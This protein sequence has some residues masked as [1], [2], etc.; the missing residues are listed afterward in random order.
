MKELETQNDDQQQPAELSED[1]SIDLSSE[2]PELLS[3][4]GELL[5]N[6]RKELGLTPATVSKQ[7]K[8]TASLIE[9]IENDNYANIGGLTYVKGYL[10]MYAKLLKLSEDEVMV[11]FEQS[12]L[13][14]TISSN[15]EKV[16]LSSVD[17]GS[18]HDK[19]DIKK[20]RW[21]AYA[22]AAVVSLIFINWLVTSDHQAAKSRQ[23][24]VTTTTQTE[25][26][27][28]A[29]SIPLNKSIIVPF[30]HSAVESDK[31][32]LSAN[33]SVDN[34]SNTNND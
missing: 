17:L 28:A 18:H 21:F 2:P 4:L 22:G 20:L 33:K 25:S 30:H 32:K 31:A 10:R 3:S 6:K 29:N 16:K 26:R 9:D 14:D 11:A 13:E 34:D 12:N 8:L 23:A 1:M 24:L 27:V 7:L 19:F 15:R 5:A